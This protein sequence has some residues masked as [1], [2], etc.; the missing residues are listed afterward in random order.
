MKFS[1]KS[2][3]TEEDT[4]ISALPMWNIIME[5]G[6]EIGAYPEEIFE[7]EQIDNGRK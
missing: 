1:L 5:N 4:Y 3:C 7:R 6:T 2:R